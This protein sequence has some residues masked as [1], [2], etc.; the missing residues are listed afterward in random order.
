MRVWAT[1]SPFG[2]NVSAV[3]TDGAPREPFLGRL[4][5]LCGMA[6]GLGMVV[7]VTLS[8]GNGNVSVHGQLA[9]LERH[10]RAVTTLCEALRPFRNVYV[11][12]GNERSCPDPRHVPFADLKPL[13]EHARSLDPERLVTASAASDIPREEMADYLFTAGVD[14]LCP[15]RPRTPESPGQTEAKTRAYYAWMEELGRVVPVHYQEPHRRGWKDDPDAA[16]LLADLEGAVRGGAAGWCLHNGHERTRPDGRPRRS[17]DLS[18]EEGRLFD[19]LD[20][21]EM[22]V[23]RRA[24]EVVREARG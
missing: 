23:V 24:A 18:A 7:D 11:D 17:F 15:H 10:M 3:E 8:R 21:E 12:L 20:E 6:D 1:W 13:R 14:M 5:T 9:T 19:Q 2:R 4:V 22:E 16:Y